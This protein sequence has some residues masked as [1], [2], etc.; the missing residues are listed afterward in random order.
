MQSF[1]YSRSFWT[2]GKSVNIHLVCQDGV[3]LMR[4][5]WITKY[6]VCI[7]AWTWTHALHHV[8]FFSLFSRLS[9][10]YQVKDGNTIHSEGD[11]NG[12]ISWQSV[13]LLYRIPLLKAI[14][15]FIPIMSSLLRPLLPGPNTSSVWHTLRSEKFKHPSTGVNINSNEKKWEDVNNSSLTTLSHVPTN[16]IYRHWIT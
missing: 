16:T 6:L 2:N 14:A 12:Q 7:H 3:Q 4:W 13:Q 9:L 5:P 10:L 1:L 15:L 11:M 8:P